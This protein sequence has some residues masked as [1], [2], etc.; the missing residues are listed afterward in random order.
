ML[1]KSKLNMLLGFSVVKR[2]LLCN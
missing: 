2:N 1:Q